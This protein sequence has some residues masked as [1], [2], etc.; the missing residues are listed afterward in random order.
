MT[1]RL[2]TAIIT[3]EIKKVIREVR[4]GRYYV[5]R[6]M[7]N[8]PKWDFKTYPFAVS[9]TM[10]MVD[11]DDPSNITI[12]CTATLEMMCRMPDFTAGL[13]QV[14]DQVLDEMRD[15]HRWIADELQKIKFVHENGKSDSLFMGITRLPT[16]EIGDSNNEL[17]GIQRSLVLEY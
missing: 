8:W 3:E 12:E 17:Q 2:S 13:R 5:H 1:N 11:E 15:D 4:G 6:G 14:D 9:L 7:I 10:P 16:I